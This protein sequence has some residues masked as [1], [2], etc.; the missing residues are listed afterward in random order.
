MNRHEILA[1]LQEKDPERLDILWDL[2]DASR[3]RFVGDAVHIRGLIEFSNYCRSHC[4]YCGMRGDRKSLVR[5]RMTGEEI[6]ASAKEAV[7]RGY[8]TIVMQSGED[9]DFN[10]EWLADVIKTI[11]RE[12][13]LAVTLSCGERSESELAR[14]REAGADRYYL[15]FETSDRRLWD[16][17]HPAG[18]EGVPHRLDILPRIKKLGYEIGSG[19]MVG[20][21]GQTWLSLVED[22]EWFRRLDLDMIGCGPYVP[23]EDTPLGKLH[24]DLVL[25]ASSKDQVPNTDLITYKVMALTR[26]VLPKVNIPSTTALATIN[27]ES[28]HRLGLQ[29]GANVLMVNLTPLQYRRLYEIYPSKAGISESDQSQAKRV[30]TLLGGLGRTAGEGPGTSPNYEAPQIAGA[31]RIVR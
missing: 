14:L 13:P 8:G 21:P 25:S 20:I 3:R 11:K 29:R 18:R 30:Q 16:K 26:L 7:S 19:I 15:R 2:A 6:I 10:F 28:G 22:I 9:P 27:L 5:Y 31:S 4:H 23:H 1:W 12:T 24:R 17:I